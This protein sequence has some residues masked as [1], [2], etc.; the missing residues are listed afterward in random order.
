MRSCDNKRVTEGVTLQRLSD[1]C[2]QQP[3]ARRVRATAVVPSSL[4][5]GCGDVWAEVALHVSQFKQLAL[6]CCRLYTLNLA[7]LTLKGNGGCPPRLTKATLMCPPHS[8]RP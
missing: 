5:R 1:A 8:Q 4:L 2:E 6:S 7:G 3:I